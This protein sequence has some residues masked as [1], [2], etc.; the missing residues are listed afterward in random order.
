[1][2]DEV[3]KALNICGDAGKDAFAGNA[4]GCIGMGAFDARDKFDYSG[5]VART[6]EAGVPVTFYYGKTDTACNYKGGQ[7]MADTIEWSGRTEYSKSSY[8]PLIISGVE[9]GQ[10]KSYGGLTFVQVKY[11][12]IIASTFFCCCCVCIYMFGIEFFYD[13]VGGKR[14][15]HG[16]NGSTCWFCCSDSNYPGYSLICEID[17]R[18]G[19]RGGRGN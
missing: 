18:V 1:L 12:R 17:E 2:Q 9:A 13:F 6:L 16:S 10:V 15:A 5:A 7:S 14:W 11:L 19:D 3:L 8:Q 4:G